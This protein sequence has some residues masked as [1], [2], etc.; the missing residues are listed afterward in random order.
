VVSFL[1][2]KYRTGPLVNVPELKGWTPL[3]Y[4]CSNNDKDLV[5]Q[6]LDAGADPNARYYS[7]LAGLP[8]CS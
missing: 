7:R 8:L 4:A 1:I 3:H 2:S 6:L 5:Q